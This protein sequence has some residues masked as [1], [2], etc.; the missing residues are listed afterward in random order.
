[1]NCRSYYS[2]QCLT[3]RWDNWVQCNNRPCDFNHWFYEE[4]NGWES[5]IATRWPGNFVKVI[6]YKVDHKR[7]MTVSKLRK[8]HKGIISILKD[9]IL[10]ESSEYTYTLSILPNFSRIA[11]S[12][13]IPVILIK[14]KKQKQKRC[15]PYPTPVS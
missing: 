9:V 7:Q 5:L 2:Q 13:R 15:H 3:C 6:I 8:S 1:M 4:I 12:W 10:A 14:Q 11:F